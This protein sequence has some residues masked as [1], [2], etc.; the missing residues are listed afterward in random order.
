MI[1][2]ALRSNPIYENYPA[3]FRTQINAD[4]RRFIITAE[5]YNHV[6]HQ[7]EP[8]ITADD[9]DDTDKYDYTVINLR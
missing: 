7:S 8:Q 9:T 3:I 6:S 4:T 2:V 1:S 5:Q